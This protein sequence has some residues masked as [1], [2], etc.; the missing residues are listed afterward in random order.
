VSGGIGCFWDDQ[1]WLG[2]AIAGLRDKNQL[3]NGKFPG[4]VIQRLRT[5]RGKL[6]PIRTGNNG[7]DLDSFRREKP[8][9]LGTFFPKC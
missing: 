9:Q 5:P 3:F 6:A 7:A 2:G 4:P 1:V 8:E